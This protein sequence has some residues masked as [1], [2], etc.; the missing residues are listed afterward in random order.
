MS[1]TLSSPMNK[2]RR[3]ALLTSGGDAPGM[4]AAIR[5]I[6]LA[7]HHYQI[8]VIGFYH[9]YNGLIEHESVE[10]TLSH[11][12][13]IIYK[14][15]TILKSARCPAMHNIT[16]IKQAVNT[17]NKEKIDALIVIGG[18]GS[19]QGLLEI[20][21]HWPKQVI[22]LPGTIDN[23]LDGTDY[24]IGFSTAINTAIEA[25]DKIR[26]T[27]NAF[28]RIFII[29][30]MGRHSGFIAF[31]VGIACAAEQVL[32]FEN[33]SRGDEQNTLDKLAKEINEV[34]KDKDS[35]YLIVMAENLWDGG[36][37]ALTEQL[38]AQKNIDATACTLGHIQRGGSPV[39]KDR[40]LATKMGVTAVQ[41]LTEEKTAIMVAEQCNTICSVP[42]EETVEHKKR[43]SSTLIQ[44]QE[45]I[46]ALVPKVEPETEQ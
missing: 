1:N 5:A 20:A 24:T 32:S 7:A 4:N 13:D 37:S 42:L 11:V 46:F 33:F 39:A 2:I 18:D 38:K 44:A 14:G 25:I 9:G 30:V 6:V 29:E 31:N 35:S 40:I 34:K 28:D 22:G 15:G 8:D 21:Q 19:F 3:I 12:N 43:V 16:G 26:D 27:A 10:L 41:M 45:N 23:D 36:I 17:L